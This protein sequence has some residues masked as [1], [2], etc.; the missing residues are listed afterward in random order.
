MNIA[1]A[2]E[3]IT[4]PSSRKARLPRLGFLGVG[5]IGRNRLA[6]IAA[7]PLA[8]IAAIADPVPD[9][10]A[11]ARELAPAAKLVRNVDEL[12]ELG[13]D[14]IVIATPSA[15]HAEQ[16]IRALKAGCAVFCQKPLGRTAPETAEVLE[17]ARTANR[18]LGVD[19]C[20]RRTHAMQ[21]IKA[22]LEAAAIGDVF[23]VDACFHNAY[24]PDKAWFYDPKLSGGGCVIDLGIHMVDLAL[25]ALGFPAVRDVQSRLFSEGKPLD[26]PKRAVEDYATAQLTLETGTVVNLSCSWKLNAG[27]DAVI[28]LTL[29]GRKGGLRFSNVDGSFYDFTAEH[30]TGTRRLSLATGPDSWGGRTIA[31]WARELSRNPS[32]NTEIESLVHVANALDR[33][34]GRS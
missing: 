23:A 6:A 8:E 33:I 13:L 26:D 14:A 29:Y 5:W 7:E 18:L 4:T 31:D 3:S 19:L 30:F 2:N 15:L 25:W 16:S 1:L 20:Y 34:Y 10:A 9:L 17:A 21:Q 28:G 24:G 12:L 32:F 22:Q 27:S 11:Q